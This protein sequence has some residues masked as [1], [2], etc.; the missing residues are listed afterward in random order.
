MDGQRLPRELKP[1]ARTTMKDEEGAEMSPEIFRRFWWAPAGLAATLLAGSLP[2][3]HWIA[4]SPSTVSQP[5]ASALPAALAVQQS[6]P[7]PCVGAALDSKPPHEVHSLANAT[8][9][10]AFDC[11]SW[12]TLVALNWAAGADNGQ[13]DT[14]KVFGERRADGRCRVARRKGSRALDDHARR[15][16]RRSRDADF[17]RFVSAERTIRV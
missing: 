9:Q 14:T 8:L 6:P 11:F 2:A 1:I 15:D 10:E 17:H 4:A 13:P 3:F 5:V 7:G 12:Q 16:V